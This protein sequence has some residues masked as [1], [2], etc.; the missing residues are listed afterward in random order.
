MTAPTVAVGEALLPDEPPCPLVTYRCP[1]CDTTIQA[2]DGGIGYCWHR[3]TA[4]WSPSRGSVMK[5]VR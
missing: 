2:V 4:L 1:K 5:V 3:G